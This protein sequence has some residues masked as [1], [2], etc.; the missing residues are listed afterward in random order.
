M[1]SDRV[2]DLKAL[3]DQLAENADWDDTAAAEN[4][5][6]R[7]EAIGRFIA[8]GV[9][10]LDEATPFLWEYY[11][12]A[13]AEF[14]SEER[15]R[16]GIP[17]IPASA[18]IWEHVQFVHAPEWCPGGGPLMPGRSYLSFEG[19]VPWEP[20]HGLQLVFEDGQRVC[21]VSQYDGH[22]TVAHACGDASRLGVVFG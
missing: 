8:G 7:S 1:A 3:L 5:A 10:L 22:V 19:E 15:A 4:L 20:E 11:R 12:D 14:T 21:K 13:A 2:R 18:D 16:Y 9:Q 6:L 17:E